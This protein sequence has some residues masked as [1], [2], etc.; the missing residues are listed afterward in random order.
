MSI[1]RILRVYQVH[2]VYIARNDLKTV[3]SGTD[4]MLK[5]IGPRQNVS[6]NETARPASFQTTRATNC[7]APHALKNALSP[8]LRA[9]AAHTTSSL[10]PAV[11]TDLHKADSSKRRG[12]HTSICE[13]SQNV[14]TRLGHCPQYAHFKARGRTHLV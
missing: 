13:R 6:N 1:S 10:L 5:L 9:P 11:E 8:L 12:N 7:T 14:S 3:K 2:N 4:P